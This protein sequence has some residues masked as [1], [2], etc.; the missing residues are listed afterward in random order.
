MTLDYRK[1]PPRGRKRPERR[2]TCAFWFLTGALIGAFGVGFAW[3]THEE[4]PG[5]DIAARN[6][7]QPAAA[8]REKPQFDFPSLLEKE[9]VV[10]PKE[11][12]P[13]PLALPPTPD[14]DA[15]G[16]PAQTAK[17][18]APAPPAPATS[19]GPD[20]FI[21]QVGSFRKSTD[22]ERLK[23]ELALL[24]V[25]TSIQ[26]VTIE[27]GQTYHRVRTGAY[28][29]SDANIVRGR[30]ESGGHEALMMRAR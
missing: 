10:V 20:T 25:Q 22:A 16:T 27:N 26:Q 7:A 4:T 17:A 12:P 29:K 8:E 28:T 11:T 9:E 21:L 2:G 18:T 6:A 23:A 1:G 3:M 5:T 13:Q 19:S 15:P 30:L 24:G 14:P